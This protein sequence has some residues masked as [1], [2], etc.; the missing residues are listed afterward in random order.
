M[1]RVP[2][3]T[4]E[5]YR[6]ADGEWMTDTQWHN[7]IFWGKNGVF[8]EKTL[9]KGT[10]ISVDGRLVNRSYVDREGATR[11]VTE[12]VVNEA[13]LIQRRSS[14]QHADGA[15]GAV[16]VEGPEAS[17]GLEKPERSAEDLPADE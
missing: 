7:L 11:Y 6:N 17:E 5:R 2:L 16:E 3:A 15:D 9:K 12:V 13:L 4:N 8:A 10:E 1:T 14:Q